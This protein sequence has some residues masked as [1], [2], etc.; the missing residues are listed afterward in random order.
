MPG[1]AL[2]KTVS[3]FLEEG[4]GKRISLLQKLACPE[5]ADLGKSE[6]FSMKRRK[7]TGKEF[8]FGK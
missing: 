8:S 6:F 7:T 1:L 4:V 2:L 5:L 3:N